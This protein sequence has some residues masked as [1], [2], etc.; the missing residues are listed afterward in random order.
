M[1]SVLRRR[2][3]NPGKPKINLG[4]AGVEGAIAALRDVRA[5]K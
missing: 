3:P 4:Q 1:D 5:L 2:L